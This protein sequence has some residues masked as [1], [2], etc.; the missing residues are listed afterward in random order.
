MESE[1][2]LIVSFGN[3]VGLVENADNPVVRPN[4]YINVIKYT[5]LSMVK[6]KKF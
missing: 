4:K 5:F 6:I 3:E 2:H 1:S